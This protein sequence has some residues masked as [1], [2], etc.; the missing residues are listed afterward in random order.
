MHNS[1]SKCTLMTKA[2]PHGEAFIF[3]RLFVLPPQLIALA[4]LA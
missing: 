2:L 1:L 3:Q 4:G